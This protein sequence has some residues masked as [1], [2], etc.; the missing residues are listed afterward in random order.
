MLG[1]LYTIAGCSSNVTSM[2]SEKYQAPVEMR[3]TGGKSRQLPELNTPLTEEEA[4]DSE[5]PLTDPAAVSDTPDGEAAV[6]SE[7]PLTDP[8]AVSDTPDG[9]EATDS[10]SP[11][12]DP[13]AVSDQSLTQDAAELMISNSKSNTKNTSQPL[14]Q[15]PSLTMMSVG[16]SG[17]EDLTQTQV[18]ASDIENAAQENRQPPEETFYIYIPED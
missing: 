12:T 5:S 16:I 6:D 2:S 17:D 8:A 14:P 4:T 7:S 15:V 18:D 3:E 1:V 13:A 11:L 9:E 10:E